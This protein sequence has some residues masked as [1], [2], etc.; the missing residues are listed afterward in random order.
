MIRII[1]TIL[2]VAVGIIYYPLN[3]LYL[4]IQK[5][6]LPL[7]HRDKFLYFVFAPFYWILVGIV[8]AISIPFEEIAKL[9]AH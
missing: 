2:L 9:A 5:W 6:Y 1:A 7:W 3:L 8:S 4:R